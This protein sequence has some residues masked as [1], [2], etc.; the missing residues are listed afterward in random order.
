[1]QFPSPQNGSRVEI[2]VLHD[3]PCV[4]IIIRTLRSLPLVSVLERF[5]C[6]SERNCNHKGTLEKFFSDVRRD[7]SSL[8]DIGY[9]DLSHQLMNLA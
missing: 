7:L 2:L 8:V 4:N 1:M 3:P 6:N 5:D 9:T